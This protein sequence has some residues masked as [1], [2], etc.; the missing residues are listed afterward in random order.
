MK[1]VFEQNDLEAKAYRKKGMKEFL[2]MFHKHAELIYV[3]E[4]ELCVRIDGKTK[5]LRA[6]EM[7]VTFPYAVH[8]YEKSEKAEVILVLFSPS[9]AGEFQKELTASNPEVPFIEDAA[10]LLPILDKLCAY[11]RKDVRMLHAY[12][13][14][15]LGEVYRLVHL[16]KTDHM[17]ISAIQ[18]ILSYCSEHYRENIGIKK[19]AEALYL[20]ESYVSKVFAGKLGCS[21]RDYIN[22]LRIIEAKRLL[23]NTNEKIVD[24]MFAAGFENQSSFNRIFFAETGCTPSEYRKRNS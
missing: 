19:V 1:A 18:Q 10:P 20:S 7:C 23:Q 9:V 12:L 5:T 4:G 24:I 17:D 15:L 22:T 16:K 6:G 21:F 3:S 13:R 14:V 11:Y 2:P 8:S